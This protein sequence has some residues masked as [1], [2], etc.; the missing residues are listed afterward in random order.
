MHILAQGILDSLSLLTSLRP[1]SSNSDLAPLAPSPS[2]LHKLHRTLPI[3]PTQGWHGTLPAERPTALRDDSTLYIKSTA[4]AIP[5]APPAA[6]AT[7]PTPTQPAPVQ[8][9]APTPATAQAYAGYSYSYAS[10]YRPELSAVQARSAALLS[11]RI[12]NPSDRP[13]A[14]GSTILSRATVR[15]DGTTAIHVFFLVPVQSPSAGWHVRGR[16]TQRD[17]TARHNCHCAHDRGWNVDRL[18]RFQRGRLCT[19]VTSTHG[20]RGRGTAWR[21]GCQP[22]SQVDLAEQSPNASANEDHDPTKCRRRMVI[23]NGNGSHVPGLREPYL[24][25][26]S[27]RSLANVAEPFLAFSSGSDSSRKSSY[28]LSNLEDV[29]SGKNMFGRVVWRCSSLHRLTC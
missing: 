26:P 20:E 4:T 19:D 23:R 14:C 27:H 9:I 16:I 24:T 1:R 25:E 7:T 2:A 11:Q 17:S 18:S 15:R 5:S 8:P 13:D 10:P 21:R 3:A 12:P 28:A 29:S 22:L 6:P